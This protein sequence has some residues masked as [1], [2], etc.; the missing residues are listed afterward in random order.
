MP[1]SI[2]SE[3]I[4]ASLG[5]AV[6]ASI[7]YP[8]EV[9]KTKMQAETKS[10]KSSGDENGDD[11]EEEEEVDRSKFTMVEYAQYLYKTQGMQVFF[12]G[13]ETSAFQSATEKAL[14]FFAYTGL[15]GIYRGFNGGGDPKTFGSL[16]LGCCAEWAHLPITLPLD[17]WTTAIQTN[18]NPSQ[19]PMQLLLTMLSDKVRN[20]GSI[21]ASKFATEHYTLMA[22]IARDVIRL[23]INMGT[24]SHIYFSSILQ[25]NNMDNTTTGYQGNVQGYSGLHSIVPQASVAVYHF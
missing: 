7:L 21:V 10:T 22:G 11:K 3:V 19:G 18:T 2:A 20:V 15:K 14:Y 17:C 25:L 6:S 24:F 1:E 9:L 13:V 16:L 12:A 4:S 23:S 5:G 8:L